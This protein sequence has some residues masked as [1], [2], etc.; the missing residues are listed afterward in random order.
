MRELRT[1]EL[2]FVS[3]GMVCTPAKSGNVLYGISDPQ[4]VGPFLIDLYE[5]LIEATSYMFERVAN[6]W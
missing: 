2:D 6:A 1:N 5:G 4:G 3:G